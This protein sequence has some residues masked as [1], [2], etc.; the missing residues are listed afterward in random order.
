M[1]KIRQIVVNV[2]RE[3]YE[4]AVSEA[5]RLSAL[6][7]IKITWHDVYRNWARVGR[8]QK[9]FNPHPPVRG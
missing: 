7:N 4:A 6:T 5:E 8:E 3:E 1:R 2:P 9:C